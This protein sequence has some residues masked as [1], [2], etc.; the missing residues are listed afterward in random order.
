MPYPSYN[1]IA[2]AINSRL[3]RTAQQVH[4]LRQRVGT[5]NPLCAG[6]QGPL[7][8]ERVERRVQA[9]ALAQNFI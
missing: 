5:E 2:G 1:N 4:L 3:T 6:A 8:R 9:A 7:R